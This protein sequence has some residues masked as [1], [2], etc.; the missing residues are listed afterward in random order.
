MAW[1]GARMSDQ[2]HYFVSGRCFLCGRLISFDPARV[3]SVPLDEDGLPVQAP[4]AVVVTRAP[5]CR[6]CV[7]TV[8]KDRRRAGAPTWDEDERIWEPVEGLPE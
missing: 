1:A 3:P 2:P 7:L 8:N 6:D 5:L 4:G